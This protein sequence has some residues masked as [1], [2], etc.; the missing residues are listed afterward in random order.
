MNL[1]YIWYVH[2]QPYLLYNIYVFNGSFLA[3]YFIAS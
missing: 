1:K 3:M 2:G